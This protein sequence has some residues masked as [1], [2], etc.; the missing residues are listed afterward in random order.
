[1]LFSIK[2]GINNIQLTNRQVFNK[3]NLFVRT[4][5]GKK[6]LTQIKDY[7]V[8]SRICKTK[9]GKPSACTEG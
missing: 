8:L 4:R 2:W 6:Y 1:M 9:N 7:K 3:L 5:S